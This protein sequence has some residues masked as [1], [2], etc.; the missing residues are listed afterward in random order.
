MAISANVMNI[1]TTESGTTVIT[2]SLPDFCH[3]ITAPENY[4]NGLPVIAAQPYGVIMVEDGAADD[5]PV[6]CMNNNKEFFSIALSDLMAADVHDTISFATEYEWPE[7]VDPTKY[8]AGLAD[9]QITDPQNGQALIYDATSEKW[10][11][12]NSG[13]GG[14]SGYEIEKTYIAEEQIVSLTYDEE[15]HAYMGFITTITDVPENGQGIAIVNGTNYLIDFE[16][17]HTNGFVSLGDNG[18][19]MYQYP[20]LM[21]GSIVETANPNL[22][23][24]TE[25]I[26]IN[27]N[28]KSAV[29]IA[30]DVYW[31]RYAN[32]IV[33][34]IEN[35]NAEFADIGGNATIVITPSDI[36]QDGKLCV[37]N[38]DDQTYAYTFNSTR[39]EFETVNGSSTP[40]TLSINSDDEV[41]IAS[42]NSEDIGKTVNLE[43]YE[44]GTELSP[45]FYQ[46]FKNTFPELFENSNG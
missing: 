17:L 13:G 10:V 25:T 41:V 21:F 30:A 28:F 24:Y 15:I 16:T 19:L 5:M 2:L 3:T 39:N 12:G 8:L 37:L 1:E 40:Y 46:V 31:L 11:N 14:N 7:D 45:Y 33:P 36:P 23:L 27:K 43:L 32:Y 18:A 42:N 29:R 34:I 4:L 6:V 26:I 38:V 22:E 35:Q 20:D 44:D 9:V